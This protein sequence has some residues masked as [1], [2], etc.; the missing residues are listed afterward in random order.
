M[1]LETLTE[2]DWIAVR[3]LYLL[4]ASDPSCVGLP[5]VQKTIRYYQDKTR[6]ADAPPYGTGK[7]L[8]AFALLN[9]EVPYDKVTFANPEVRL[10]RDV[11]IVM[12]YGTGPSEDAGSKYVVPDVVR[13]EMEKSNGANP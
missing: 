8:D 2:A 4:M 9:K 7:L 13:Q 11:A 3:L 6:P 12:H 5:D 10:T 1:A